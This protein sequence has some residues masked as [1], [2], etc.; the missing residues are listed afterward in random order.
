[1]PK[2]SDS[3]NSGESIADI[4]GHLS[5]AISRVDTSRSIA[6]EENA[7]RPV[8]SRAL[9]LLDHRARSE[10][11]LRDRLLD[12]EFPQ[13]SVDTVIADLVESG[14][15]DDRRFAE[16]WV[17]QRRTRRGKSRSVLREELR[18]KGVST[19]DC[20]HALAVVSDDDE[21]ELARHVAEDRARRIRTVPADRKEKY[22]HLRRI[23]A[24]LARRGF[25]AGMSQRIAHDVVEERITE[26]SSDPDGE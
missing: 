13:A 6:K 16:E 20:D 19:A 25:S 18:R 26:L 24:A 10:Q 12:A 9:R 21:Q 17:R 1:M 3:N 4:I 15:I 23:A 14:L 8:R 2:S 22:D 7:V 5:E 11:E